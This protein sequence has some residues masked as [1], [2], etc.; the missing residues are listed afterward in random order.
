LNRQVVNRPGHFFGMVPWQRPPQ[1]EGFPRQEFGLWQFFL[2]DLK[3]KRCGQ[4][5]TNVCCL[6]M[7][8]PEELFL[9]DGQRLAVHSF[10]LGV[11]AQVEIRPSNS[12]KQFC[13]NLRL[14][15]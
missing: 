13:L 14:V 10:C 1:S 4:M 5:R 8:R 3:S 11:S 9:K 2:I 7:L 15:V 12:K 6:R